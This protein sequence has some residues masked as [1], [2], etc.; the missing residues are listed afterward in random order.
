MNQVNYKTL[1]PSIVGA[2]VL[3][4]E[5]S[6]GHQ[7]SASIQSQMVTDLVTAASIVVTLWGIWKNHKKVTK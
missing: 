6:T 7:V 4:Y 5:A 1:I 3:V 2:G